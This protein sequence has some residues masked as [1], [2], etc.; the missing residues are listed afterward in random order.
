MGCPGRHGRQD[1]QAR[2]RGPQE[3]RRCSL[4]CLW[5]LGRGGLAPGVPAS[6]CRRSVVVPPSLGTGRPAKSSAR[7]PRGRR[8]RRLLRG[9]LW[10]AGHRPCPRP[11]AGRP[12]TP[13]A[14]PVRR[15]RA[16]H[17]GRRAGPGASVGAWGRRP[18]SRSPRRRGGSRTVQ[19]CGG[20]GGLDDLDRGA[21]SRPRSERWSTSM[22]SATVSSPWPDERQRQRAG[23]LGLG[24]R[25]D[26]LGRHLDGDG[27]GE[28]GARQVVV[29]GLV[30]GHEL[31]GRLDE[32]GDLA[33][34]RRCRSPVTW[35]DQ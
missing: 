14:R 31:H 4:T 29:G 12:G 27:A 2:Q 19:T 1:D 8:G 13:T 34:A 26:L 7:L 10:A 5:S 21:S 35:P 11:A 22:A 33:A 20:G 9:A 3:S 25:R 18:A 23:G 32:L 24:Q 28:G 16:G 17:A 15:G 6:A 30:D